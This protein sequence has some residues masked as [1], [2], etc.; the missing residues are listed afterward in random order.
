MRELKGKVSLVTGGSRG[1]GRA[2]ALALA[3]EGADVAIN[4]QRAQ[5][6]ADQ[7][8]EEITKLGVRAKAYRTDV[9]NAQDVDQMIAGIL[10]DLGPISI[11]VNC[12]GITR[13]KTFVKMPRQMWDEVIAT[14]LGGPY[15]V[16]H[17]ALPSMLDAGWGRIINI[18]SIVG[19]WG[20]YGQANYAATKAGLIGFTQ[21]LSRELAR[22]NITV[23]AVAPGFIET[24]M[25]KDL[26]EAVKLQVAAMTPLGRMGKPEEVASAVAFLASPKAAFIT[27][28]VIGVN[29]GMYM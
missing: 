16:T 12:A 22:K 27:G 17:A 6:S 19:Q 1:I 26:P 14:N 2:I 13:D 20:N 3:E 23:N 5:Q 28:Q 24:D 9:A 4:Y 25:T 15:N 8:C 10:N 11:L 7:V 29:G 21:T 18:S